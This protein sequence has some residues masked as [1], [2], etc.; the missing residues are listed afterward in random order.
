MA[1]VQFRGLAQQGILRDPSPYDLP[2]TAWSGGMNMRFHANRAERAPAFKTAYAPSDLPV[3]I[4][5]RRPANSS[6]NLFYVT[7]S[8]S[9]KQFQSGQVWDVSPPSASLAGT[10]QAFTATGLGDVSY[11]N[12]PASQPYYFGPDSTAFAALPGWDTT[13]SCRSMRAFS[14]YLVALNVTKGAQTVTNMVKWSD[15][16]LAG[17]P[18]GSWDADDQTTNAGENVMEELTSP[19][20]DGCA[21]RSVFIIYASDQAW[22]MAQIDNQE[23]FQFSRLGIDGGLIAPNCVEE[24][25]GIH[26]CFGLTDIYRHDSLTQASLCD[27]QNRDYIFGTLNRKLS[28]QFF[29]LYS[30]EHREVIFCYNTMDPDAKW[31][32]ATG[33]NRAAVYSLTS[34]TWS[35][36]DLPNVT[37]GCVVSLNSG[38]TYASYDSQANVTYATLT[39][40]Y[41]DLSGTH[42][43]NVVFS[44]EALSGSISS[45]RLVAYDFINNG[46]LPQYAAEAE[47]NAPA[48]L[49]RIG[50]DLDTIGS[51]LTTYKQVRRVYPQMGSSSATTPTTIAVGGSNSPSGMV[52]WSAAL[53]FDPTS[54]YKVDV[55][56][57]GRYLAFQVT[58]SALCDF[59]ISG[60]DADVVSA[61]R[62]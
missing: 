46:A 29:T 58:V 32:G 50:L 18:P 16:T 7:P 14:D 56:I 40:S 10:E 59:S 43:D 38:T 26:Y 49:Q 15:L 45:S 25:N 8:G 55:R 20:V 52:S 1:I 57:G 33:C 37:A 42:D 3:Y 51:D 5:A 4:F 44:S 62:R 34:G 19:I 11:I 30:P 35:F 54:Q 61:G 31:Q 6:D 36:L 23:I 27:G 53:S 22:Q 24:V 21:M 12:S 13:W 9:I 41:L 47:C 17:Q 28:E 60:F 39:G 48:V 2:L